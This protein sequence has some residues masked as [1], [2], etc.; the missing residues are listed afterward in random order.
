MLKKLL[1]AKIILFIAVIFTFS[2]VNAD[3][4]YGNMQTVS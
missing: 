3:T 4:L 2:Q 1:M